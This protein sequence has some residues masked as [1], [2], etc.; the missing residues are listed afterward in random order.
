VRRRSWARWAAWRGRKQHSTLITDYNCIC[1]Y[2]VYVLR[3]SVDAQAQLG[4]VGGLAW[5][6]AAQLAAG[7]MH[8]HFIASYCAALDSLVALSANTGAAD[9]GAADTGAADTG[10][11]TGADTGAADTGAANTG[12]DTGVDTG[13]D[14]GA[15]DTGGHAQRAVGARTLPV[16]AST[17]AA[18]SV[19]SPSVRRGASDTGAARRAEPRQTA[20]ARPAAERASGNAAGLRRQ[21]GREREREGERKREGGSPSSAQVQRAAPSDAAR[22]RSEGEARLDSAVASLHSHAETRPASTRPIASLWEQSGPL[23]AA[24]PTAAPLWV[25]PLAL[26]SVGLFVASEAAPWI[27]SSS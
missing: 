7:P 19:R 4:K 2:T 27:L 16:S 18:S 12:M 15:A 17:V 11:D 3:L 10:V 9:T 22:G 23:A 14:T 26:A 6:E 1:Y 25:S 8:V 5:Q 24:G 13:V 21:S 20:P